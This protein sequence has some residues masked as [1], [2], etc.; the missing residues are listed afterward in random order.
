M[1]YIPEQLRQFVKIRA[2]YCC[3]YCRIN[4]EDDFF[5]LEVDHIIAEK[6]QGTTSEA[7]LCLSCMECNRHKGSDFASFD[8]VTKQFAFLFNP[9]TDHW[10]D[11]FR[12]DGAEI[13]PLTL[14]GSVIVFLLKMNDS[15]R[16][17]E[18]IRLLNLDRYPC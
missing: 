15:E 3:E 14:T 8:P 12:L 6:H 16:L 13:V 9:R 1:T 10:S 4:L 5:P 11:H 17:R 7:N 2:N 18:R